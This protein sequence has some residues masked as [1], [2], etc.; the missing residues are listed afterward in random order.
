MNR[1]EKE[2]ENILNAQETSSYDVSWVFHSASHPPSSPI[3]VVLMAI[4]RGGNV[5]E[6]G[7]I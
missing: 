1:K 5:G 2:K 6:R 4:E 3:V 7:L